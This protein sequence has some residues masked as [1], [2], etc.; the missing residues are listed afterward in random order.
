MKSPILCLLAGT[1]LALAAC[2]T[3]NS[4]ARHENTEKLRFVNDMAYTHAV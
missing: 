4:H 1:T 3:S 2:S